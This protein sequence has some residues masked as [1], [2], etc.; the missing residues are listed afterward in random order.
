MADSLPTPA[1]VLAALD[2]LEPLS[3]PGPN[4]ARCYSWRE[5]AGKLFPPK[6][7]RWKQPEGQAHGNHFSP[8]M[9]FMLDL[10]QE[11]IVRGV[12]GGG[13][14]RIWRMADASA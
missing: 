10:E 3:P 1:D 9:R 2:R 5:L 12:R 6:D 14:S 13:R 7:P 8:A 11:R 4:G